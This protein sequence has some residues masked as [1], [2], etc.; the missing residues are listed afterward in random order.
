M[1]RA[2]LSVLVYLHQLFIDFFFLI[3]EEEEETNLCTFT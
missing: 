2:L 1:G 3:K